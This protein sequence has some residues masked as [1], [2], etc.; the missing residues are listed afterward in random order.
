MPDRRSDDHRN[1]PVE[2]NLA[3]ADI[4][5]CAIG[6]QFDAGLSGFPQQFAEAGIDPVRRSHPADAIVGHTEN[7]HGPAPTAAQCRQLAQMALA[8]RG[9][10]IGEKSPAP[11]F[12]ETDVLDFNMTF[13]LRQT[14][15]KIRPGRRRTHRPLPAAAR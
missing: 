13:P 3:P 9:D 8:A 15:Q 2:P 6:Q 4:E 11:L 5:T 1:F 14:D 7:H 10:R 12:R